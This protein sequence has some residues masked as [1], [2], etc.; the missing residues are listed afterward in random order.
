MTGSARKAA[1]TAL[2]IAVAASFLCGLIEFWPMRYPALTEAR[3]GILVEHTSRTLDSDF[4]V[5]S[6]RLG[7]RTHLVS[8]PPPP[9]AA[10]GDRSTW[11]PDSLSVLVVLGS[12]HVPDA[13]LYEIDQFIMR[14]GR[15]AFFLDGAELS[16]DRTEATVVRGNLFAYAGSYGVTSEPDLVV[17]PAN[18][19]ADYPEAGGGEPYALWPIGIADEGKIARSIMP[20]PEEVVFTWASSVQSNPKLSPGATAHVLA[21]SSDTSWTTMAFADVGPGEVPEPTTEVMG[22]LPGSRRGAN[23]LAVAV[24]GETPS[25]FADMPV[26]VESE[27]GSAEFTYPSDRLSSSAATRLIVVGS[28]TMLEDKIV[29]LAPANLTFAMNALEWLAA[30]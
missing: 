9:R 27:D 2:A 11:L 15:V 6:N 21:R 24:E 18:C 23:P 30:R 5:L 19:S 28:S 4:S 20:G 17:D 13:R 26:I 3:I 8:V 12:G 7:E 25:A 10:A 1:W 14:G 29:E 22:D 16:D